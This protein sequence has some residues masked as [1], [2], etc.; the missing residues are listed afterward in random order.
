MTHPYNKHSRFY[1][2]VDCIIFGFD[3]KE[4]KLLCIRRNFEPGKGKWSLMGGFLEMDESI[5]EAAARVLYELTGIENI[6]LEQ[7]QGYGE[8]DRDPADR[9]ISIAYYAL[10]NSVKFEN[11]I[12]DKY[13]ASWFNINQIPELVFDHKEMVDKALRR[14]RRRCSTQ[15][16]GFELLPEKFT[17]P[18]LQNLYEKIFDREFDKRNFRKKI[19]SPGI[20]KKLEE[21]ERQSSRKG[22]FYYQFDKQRY[23]ELTNNGYNFDM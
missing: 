2:A 14:L 11:V 20:L 6:Y 5:D 21:K 4:L 17:L 9:V 22:A 19:L 18:Q 15:P 3:T 7:L 10:I 12:S 23:D 13:S 16:V 8:R 1:L